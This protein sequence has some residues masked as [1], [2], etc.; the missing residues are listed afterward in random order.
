MAETKEAFVVALTGGIASGKTVVSNRFLDL[1]V[2]VIDTDRIAHQLVEPGQPLLSSIVAAFGPHLIDTNARLQRRRLRELVFADPEERAQLEMMMHP[3]IREQALRQVE[4]VDEP[5]CILVIP[6]LVESVGFPGIDR[7]LLVD[8]EPEIQL[9]RVMKRDGVTRSEA[10]A[11]LDVQAERSQRLKIADDVIE[12]VG[13]L[14]DL[15][16]KV[17]KLHRK[18]L[19]L[20]GTR[21][22]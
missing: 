11:V 2:P 14:E 3:E 19:A 17:S 18:Y 22:A 7:V 5:Y 1:G 10:R 6:L 16:A 8:V 4:T 20:A 13:R 12:N 9:T 21:R 15:D